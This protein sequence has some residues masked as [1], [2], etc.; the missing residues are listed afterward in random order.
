MSEITCILE[1]RDRLGEGPIWDA[2]A[3]RLWW[4]DI[5]GQ[6]LAW[7]EPAANTFGRFD[8][9][10][11]AS[12]AAVRNDGRLLIAT[13]EGLANFDPATG[14]LDVFWSLALPDG[15][16]TNDGK[17]DTLGRFWWSTMDDDEGVRPGA[18]YRTDSDRVTELVFEGIHIANTISCTA[19]A[20][21]SSIWRTRR[22]RPSSCTTSTP[23]GRLSNRR[24]FADTKGHPGGPDGSAI[25][26]EGYLWNAQWGAWRIVR[27]APDGS[28]DRIL[29]MPVQQPTSCAF[30]GENLDTLYITSAREGLTEAELAKQPLAGGLFAFK[31][32]V[33]GLALP[34]FAG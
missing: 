21:R 28:I 15:F 5:K 14:D 17:I 18:I 8:L 32:G 2:G 29:H 25:D 10:L 30:G 24:V 26:A 27:Y 16:R 23:A 4:F 6:G 7:H 20:S 33:T 13:E 12:A 9:D 34:T 31:P 11:M 22:N 3:G 1:S 19:D